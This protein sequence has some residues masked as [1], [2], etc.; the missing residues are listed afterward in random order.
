MEG[1]K[2]ETRKDFFHKL[3]LYESYLLFIPFFFPKN[4]EE[5]ESKE[6]RKKER[7]QEEREREQGRRER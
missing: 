1:L 7:E 6:E 4:G 5:R 3:C 2:N